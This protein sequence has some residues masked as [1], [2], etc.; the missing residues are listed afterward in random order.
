[1]Q[2][3]CHELAQAPTW[4]QLV[5]KRAVNY[6]NQCYSLHQLLLRPTKAYQQVQIE[7]MI[8]PQEAIQSDASE[9]I[10]SKFKR[11]YKVRRV[12]PSMAAA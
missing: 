7:L 8:A 12:M 10:P 9:S 4:R 5:I 3:L 2:G 1:M 11:E 6:T